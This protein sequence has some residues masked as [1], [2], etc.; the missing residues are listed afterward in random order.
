MLAA[1]LLTAAASP[2]T[3]ITLVVPFAAGGPPTVARTS[4]R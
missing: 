4:A 1:P 3:R 2:S